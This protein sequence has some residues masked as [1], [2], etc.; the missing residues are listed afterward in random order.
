MACNG[1]ETC[2]AATDC[3]E[4]MAL[5][6]S[7]LDDV[8]V[9]GACVESAA[10]P[11]SCI[12]EP[13]DAPR[14]EGN[15]DPDQ[16]DD[17]LDPSDPGISILWQDDPEDGT[18]LV[19]GSLKATVVTRSPTAITT[20]G[21]ALA[22]GLDQRAE[23]ILI[24]RKL[25]LRPGRAKRVKVSLRKLPVQATNLW[26]RVAIQVEWL[27]EDLTTVVVTSE[28]RWV[29]Y[30]DRYRTVEVRGAELPPEEITSGDLESPE[31]LWE[32]LK[33]ISA[34]L[35][36]LT[37]R[38]ADPLHR[39]RRVT[40]LATLRARDG[41]LRWQPGGSIAMKL[42]SPGSGP[43]SDSIFQSY[44]GYFPD[45]FTT[46]F[47]VC[48]F[49]PTE[50]IDTGFG[51][52][53]LP[54]LGFQW[55]RASRAAIRVIK[56]VEPGQDNGWSLLPQVVY[57][58]FLNENGC[59]S[60]GLDEGGYLA[61]VYPLWN[62]DGLLMQASFQLQPPYLGDSNNLKNNPEY[63]RIGP[64]NGYATAFKVGPQGSPLP[65]FANL[66]LPGPDHLTR[67]SAVVSHLAGTSDS[68][69]ELYAADTEGVIR[70]LSDPIDLAVS[71]DGAYVYSLGNHRLLSFSRNSSGGALTLEQLVEG[72]YAGF[73]KGVSGASA[74]AV[75]SDSKNVFLAGTNDTLLVAGLSKLPAGRLNFLRLSEDNVG[76]VDGLENA[77]DMAVSTD[78]KNLYVASSGDAAV[79]VFAKG[80]LQAWWYVEH[81]V[82]GQ[83]GLSGLASPQSVAVSPDGQ[84][85]YV[86]SMGKVAVFQRNPVSGALTFLEHK[87]DGQGGV[88]G[89]GT[90]Q[91]LVVSSDGQ[92]LYILG[93]TTIA[94]FHRNGDGTLN[95]F[96]QYKNKKA[97]IKGLWSGSDLVISLD[98][99]TLYASASAGDSLIVLTRNPVN[100]KL[101]FLERHGDDT[102]GVDG[103]D[104]AAAVAIS[105]DGANVYVAGR[106]DD[107]IATFDR[108]TQ[109]GAL[110]FVS[111][112]RNGPRRASRRALLI[113]ADQGCP[114]GIS[115][116][117]GWN[118][119][120]YG[121]CYTGTGL[122]IGQSPLNADPMHHCSRWKYII[123]HEIGHV[124]AGM[125]IDE[126]IHGDYWASDALSGLSSMCRCD[127]VVSANS[128]HCFQSLEDIGSALTEGWAQ[129]YA[130]RAFNN[131]GE[132][133]CS[134]AYYKEYKTGRGASDPVS[135]PPVYFNCQTPVQLMDTY[136]DVAVPNDDNN[137]G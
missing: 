33:E 128:V 6:C 127:H 123:A 35:F 74:L 65:P 55:G 32:R 93:S 47:P 37:G 92:E 111:A 135:T 78:G 112:Q 19:R 89:I 88:K 134:F 50:Y 45:L 98:G 119:A 87:Q 106:D 82:E 41:D 58:G 122:F 125:L 85:V 64:E 10:E 60:L 30:D 59:V 72:Y 18:L 4:G 108:N 86:T 83:G 14:C 69:L 1:T 104:G 20:V 52:D 99:L 67:V 13:S 130:A 15:L 77:T 21:Y 44:P 7:H 57:E 132:G 81:H 105:P 48:A 66:Y 115:P 73:A 17:G 80:L 29:R 8:C 5:D 101:S 22:T 54:Y 51:E 23:R 12:A 79:S 42:D 129:F 11:A 76:G 3:E 75:S 121:G 9:L 25:K 120:K 91:G 53:G 94:A 28:P 136:C 107:A 26:T 39:R 109:T 27:R 38:A 124:M 90:G 68:G 71:P 70:G 16:S 34:P 56:A 2:S 131:L 116:E 24:K 103:L 102:A 137:D 63:E 97:G 62:V 133:N 31:A 96:K 114:S 49:W 43:F 40:D 95:F 84:N 117:E 110:T 118:V 36:N 126:S 46:Q 61:I 113:A 100:G